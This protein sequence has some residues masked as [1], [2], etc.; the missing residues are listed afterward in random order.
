MGKA[1]IL[2]AE[3]VK[4]EGIIRCAQALTSSL[5]IVAPCI[6]NWLS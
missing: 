4:S 6:L 2:A 3:S 5:P 1:A